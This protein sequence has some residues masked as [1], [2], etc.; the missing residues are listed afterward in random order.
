MPAVCCNLAC[1]EGVMKAIS[2]TPEPIQN[3][4]YKE[5]IIPE[6]QRPYAWEEEQCEQL[7]LDVSSAIDSGN[8]KNVDDNQYFLG[9]IVVYVR[10]GNKDVWYIIDGQQRLTTL[11]ML[12]RILFGMARTMKI[13]ERIMYKTHKD[14]GETLKE[15]V[16][17]TSEVVASDYQNFKTVMRD[18]VPQ[19]GADNI[20]A[21][22][23][24]KLK[25][26]VDKYF[27]GKPAEDTKEFIQA[28]LKTAVMLPI[29]CD[30]VDDA[31]DLFQ[32]IND[33]GMHLN[34]AD[35]FKSELYKRC[36]GEKQKHEFIER[37]QDI[38]ADAD[39]P[40][41]EDLFRIL[42]HY[43]RAQNGDV[44][45]EGAL[46]AYIKDYLN[47]L[48]ADKDGHTIISI[49]ETIA[50]IRSRNMRASDFDSETDSAPVR[51]Y[52]K[53]LQSYPNI[54]WRYPLYVF[55]LKHGNKD[56]ALPSNMHKEYVLLL[57][58]TVRYF[59]I[60]GVVHNAVNAVRSTTFKV[61]R[62]IWNNTDYNEVYM[63]NIK[64]D[65]TAFEQKLQDGNYKRYKNGLILMISFC[66]PNQDAAE[67][68]T[69]LTNKYDIEHI[70][71]HKWRDHY[72]RWK[73]ES[74][75]E[76]VDTIGNL[77]PLEKKCNIAALNEFF[78]RKQE[79]YKESKIQDALDLAQQKP[80]C[81]YP[82][83][84]QKRHKQS[85]Q[86]LRSFFCEGNSPP[87]SMH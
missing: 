86:R 47:K 41:Y 50:S 21:K 35:I 10:P 43:V 6:F 68:A 81:W 13:L 65:M 71:P 19:A 20:F 28:F 42:M 73:K 18:G 75:S 60:K 72:D 14:T 17:L 69:V 39:N 24:K 70:L 30:S 33:R 62:S 63:D 9:S 52:W 37:W 66:N 34:D 79:V 51:I 4:F 31:L 32:I 55:L 82:Q 3:I 7:W 74:H 48:P 49:L 5:F 45:K 58:R 61:C 64:N 77:M 53:I 11:L 78:G 8:N 38:G 25:K 59:Y 67:Y 1:D 15:E 83:D 44:S 2:A 36:P 23:Y 56:G 29:V 40:D 27:D 76:H 85:L 80:S 12:I 57:E 87:A 46:R 84:V 54:Y 22:N 26:S 16:R